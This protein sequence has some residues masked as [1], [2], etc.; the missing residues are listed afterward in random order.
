MSCNDCGMP[1]M[2]GLPFK[3]VDGRFLCDSCA[4]KA[5]IKSSK[6]PIKND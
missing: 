5:K 6:R 4:S 1:Y 2:A 3:I